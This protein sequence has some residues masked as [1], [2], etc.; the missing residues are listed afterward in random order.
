MTLAATALVAQTSTVVAPQLA[1]ALAPH[2]AAQFLLPFHGFSATQLAYAPVPRP[3]LRSGAST[4]QI[5]D[6][7][8]CSANYV[9]TEVAQLVF[10]LPQGAIVLLD[11]S[12]SLAL[13]VLAVPAP[14]WTSLAGICI[15]GEHEQVVLLDAAGPNLLRI[16]IADLLAGQAQFQ[17]TSLP[18]VWST[19]RGIAFDVARER[20]VGFVPATGNLL[21]HSAVDPN[22]RAGLLR[23]VPEVLAFGFAPVGA[24]DRDLF[25]SSGD[26][27]M[28]TAQ[29]TWNPAGPDSLNATLRAIVQ[30]G[31][32][33]PSSPD[34]SAI[35]YDPLS[36]RVV[37]SDGEVDEMPIYAEVNLFETSRTGIVARTTTT[38]EYT[39]EP[40]G[41]TLD[42]ATRTF[43]FSDDD[44]DK[45][46][47]VA[48]GPDGLL[49][50]A[51]DLVRSFFV[52]NFCVD[53]EDVA[54]DNST[55]ELWIIGGDTVLAHKLQRGP[56]GIFD[57]TAP[58]GD[59]VLVSYDLAPFGATDPEGIAVHPTDGGIYV[60]GIPRTLLLHISTTGQL[61]R[62]ITL[63]PTGLLK[64]AGITFAPS[65]VGTGVSLFLVDRGFDNNY[66]RRENDGL[67][68]E[69]ELPPYAPGNQP[70]VVHAGPDV[71][72]VITAPTNLAGTVEDDGLPGG[73]LTIQWSLL[74]GPGQANFT[75]PTQPVT[76]VTFS[77]L[78]IYTCE[79]S[80]S[81]G[82]YTT[83]DTVVIT[84]LATPPPA[85]LDRALA[86]MH[87]DAEEAPTGVVTRS[88]TDL[89]LVVD[90]AV[91]QVVGLRFQN[92]LI[93]ASASIQ[94][95]Y[96][97]FTVDEPGAIATQLTIAGQAS[98]NPGAFTT[99]TNNVSSRPRTTATVAWTPVPWT[100]VNQAGPDQRTP[101]LASIVQEIRNRPGWSSGNSMVFVI[102]GTGCRTAGAYDSSPGVA[103]RLIISYQ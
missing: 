52:R 11:T 9:G 91:T 79:L 7:L 73:P 88:S 28:L 61:V 57:G 101:D 90:G 55:G 93:P 54:F 12:S 87:D 58:Y 49:H 47:V 77:A 99:A 85:S 72:A 66:D 81:D 89:E 2:T 50:T 3:A 4:F 35:T 46:Y 42:T 19:V 43:Y 21:Q 26:Q 1:A 64:P 41:M 69:Y 74:S 98:D 97:Q 103:A 94:S 36:D 22:T 45:I 84:V 75:A 44:R 31:S 68:L 70:P 48:T 59:D 20:I 34:P 17:S 51:D 32:W 14:T 8:L 65:T 102:T 56:N 92:V 10:A 95:A 80:A 18:P 83:T 96:I 6:P 40:S 23:P 71:T 63:P 76:G 82:Q 30:T 15:D 25:V 24:G 100:T 16:D 53:A 86:H 37:V 67:L 29:W 39:P 78:G 60:A 5:P 33:S 27:R 13:H 38:L 62:S